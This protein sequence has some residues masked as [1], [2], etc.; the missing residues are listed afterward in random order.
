MDRGPTPRREAGSPLE[1]PRVRCCSG[2]TIIPSSS[3]APQ[4]WDRLLFAQEPRARE[5][6]NCASSWE[7]WRFTAPLL[8]QSL[9]H[10]GRESAAPETLRPRSRRRRSQGR[11][12]RSQRG[13]H[14][15]PATQGCPRPPTSRTRRR[16]RRHSKSLRRR[17]KLRPRRRHPG[18]VLLLKWCRIPRRWRPSS[19][20]LRIPELL[21]S[22]TNADLVR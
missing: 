11:G 18:L 10:S 14:Q 5:G 3:G 17:S 15:R 12:N 4:P 2:A 1:R 7:L 22:G 8:L 20:G 19:S 21:G 13:R 16:R 9:R 6:D